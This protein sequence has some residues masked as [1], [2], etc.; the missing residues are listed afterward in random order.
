MIVWVRHHWR[1]LR[2]TAQKLWSAP[3]GATLNILVVGIALALPLG[4]YVLLQNARLIAAGLDHGA[5]ISVFLTTDATRDDQRKIEERLRKESVVQRIQFVSREDALANLARSANLE[6]VVGALRENPLPDGFHLTLS[7]SSPAAAENLVQV[8]RALPKVG[9][10]QADSAWSQRLAA[11]IRIANSAVALLGFLLS[12]G[13]IAVTLNTIRLEIM[14]QHEEIEVSRLIGA[15]DAYIQRP[16]YYLGTV[17]G[18][19][20]GLLAL[21]IV[22]A[23]TAWLD[24]DVATMAALYGSSFQIRLPSVGDG[25]AVTCFSAGLGWL[26]A[27]LSVS[28]YLRTI[29]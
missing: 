29:N 2:E 12:F 5:Q 6:D 25:I 19:L 7:D 26:S 9:H 27:H 23:T 28:I 3:L 22:A 24:R 20:G 14:T 13:L 10:V 15:T 21:G 11:A 18:L 1:S 8:A 4:G 17:L 16:F